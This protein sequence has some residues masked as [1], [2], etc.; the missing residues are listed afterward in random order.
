MRQSIVELVE[1][2]RTEI[3]LRD[4]NAA[5]TALTVTRHQ[6]ERKNSFSHPA[7]YHGPAS[8]L[9]HRAGAQLGIRDAIVVTRQMRTNLPDVFAAGDCVE[10]Y[11]RLLGRPTYIS[12]GTIA[13]KQGRVAGEN[14][15]GGDRAY[16][17]ALGTQ[18]LKV[19]ELAVA[20]TGLRDREARDGHFDPL[21]VST[22]VNDHKSYYPGAVPLH[23]HMTGDVSS[24][25]LLGAQIA[26][27]RKAEISKRIDKL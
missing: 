4:G 20:C 2:A 3:K 11:H 27:N 10:T 9:A 16:A 19:F 15:V 25:R 18:S 21:T 22:Q 5:W 1:S 23:I 12:L 14:A 8:P 6:L 13:H 24:G 7:Y 17:G 26:G